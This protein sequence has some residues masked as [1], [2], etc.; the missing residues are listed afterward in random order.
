M[1][2]ETMMLM[3]TSVVST[4]SIFDSSFIDTSSLPIIDDITTASCIYMLS[5]FQYFMFLTKV[6]ECFFA[7]QFSKRTCQS[8]LVIKQKK[9]RNQFET[10]QIQISIYI[11]RWC[12]WWSIAV[13]YHMRCCYMLLCHSSSSSSI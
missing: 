9:R 8:F 13:D 11:Q 1:S 10:F 7:I 6:F 2:N 5:L 4:S 12:R 3:T